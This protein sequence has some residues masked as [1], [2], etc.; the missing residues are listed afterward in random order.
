[1]IQY[2]Q[3]SK[4]CQ[5]IVDS[6]QRTLDGPGDEKHVFLIG[7]PEGDEKDR[8]LAY[9][10]QILAT[11]KHRVAYVATTDENIKQTVHTITERI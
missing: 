8:V 6:I 1:M 11:H 9:V 7:L 3:L 4:R 2:D 10:T 5:Q